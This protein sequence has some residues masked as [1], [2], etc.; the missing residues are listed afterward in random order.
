MSFFWKFM[1]KEF[2]I[3]PVDAAASTQANDAFYQPYIKV[4]YLK[5]GSQVTI[6]FSTYKLKDDALFF[7]NMSQWYQ[8]AI[9]NN[10]NSGALIYYNRDFYCVE[11]HDREVSCDGI[12]YNNVYEIPIVYLTRKQSES[13]QHI[14]EEIVEE[15]KSYGDPMEEMLRV[16]LKQLIIKATRIWKTEHA[17]NSEEVQ[18]DIEFIRQ[19][20]RLVDLHFKSI[21]V[22]A[23]YADMLSVSPKVL[24]KRLTKYGHDGPNEVIKKRII[25]EAKRLLAHT[26]LNVKEI[27]YSLGYD[28]PAYFV[29][30]FTKQTGISPLEFRKNYYEG[31]RTK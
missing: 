29:R 11:I 27:G 17:V 31:K 15:V 6:D 7:I 21:H 19:F 9:D 12:L 1:S 23:G 5:K 13:V 8:L 24:H 2:G 20:S 30:L 10:K 25:L 18:T 16:L 28:D 26:A 3:L 14:I 22:V 4:L